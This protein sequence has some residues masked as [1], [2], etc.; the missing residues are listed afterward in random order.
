MPR[1]ALGC[2]VCFSVAAFIRSAFPVRW[3]SRPHACLF[4]LPYGILGSDMFDRFVAQSAE[5][6]LGFLVAYMAGT[7]LDTLGL[8]WAARL[9]RVLAWPIVLAQC[10]CWVGEV[11]DNKLWHVFE[12]SLWGITFAFHAV[13]AALAQM[14]GHD[15]A[16]TPNAE[17]HAR[18]QLLTLGAV[19]VPYVYFMFA[20][21]VPM[22]YHQWRADEAKGTV[23]DGLH[24][25]LRRMLTCQQV[26]ND[27]AGWEEDAL[28]QCLYFA[29]GPFAARALARSL[30]AL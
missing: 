20:M 9:V 10:C 17:A 3:S 7:H 14:Y 25:G 29:V 18:T 28:W 15:T 12:E 27:W 26:A 21:D 1:W 8:T 2:A 6:S 19:S 5:V 23:Y 11:S 24:D 13:I 30:R 22:Y 16:K 4:D